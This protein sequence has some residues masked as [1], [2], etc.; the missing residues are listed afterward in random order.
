MTNELEESS[1]LKI[2]R[3]SDA[4]NFFLPFLFFLYFILF[5][6]CTSPWAARRSQISPPAYNSI[7]IFFFVVEN[8]HY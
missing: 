5:L 7:I 2:C 8:E 6:P 4:L 3:Q 1:Q